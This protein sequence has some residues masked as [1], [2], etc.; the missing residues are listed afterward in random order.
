VVVYSNDLRIKNTVA[1]EAPGNM[2]ILRIV[3]AMNDRLVLNGE[4]GDILY[5]DVPTR[6]YVDN[7]S[8][9]S[10]KA[11]VTPLPAKAPT[12]FAPLGYPPPYP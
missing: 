12:S 1:Y 10:D 6:Q 7:M 11:T 5:F 2:G 9:K 8:T 4:K 3:D